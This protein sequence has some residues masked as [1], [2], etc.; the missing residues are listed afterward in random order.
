MAQNRELFDKTERECRGSGIKIEV[1]LKEI[2][3][4]LEE[5]KRI[6]FT[7]SKDWFLSH[8]DNLN[9]YYN[10]ILG[11]EPDI[12]MVR[13]QHQRLRNFFSTNIRRGLSQVEKIDK[14][15]DQNER[16]IICG[17]SLTVETSAEDHII[18]IAMGGR[19]NF[20]NIQ[21]VCE[22]CNQGKS[23]TTNFASLCAWKI[24]NLTL[25]EGPEL[26]LTLRYAALSRDGY[27]C[28]I[29]SKT[30][31]ETRLYVV[32]KVDKQFGGQIVYDNLTTACESC[33]L[34]NGKEPGDE[35]V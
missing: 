26:T 11:Y 2:L 33:L 13:T 30:S 10:N 21:L 32:R 17:V 29:C 5:R 7:P 25:R 28:T 22:N 9:E 16:C 31:L 34:Q 4:E 24:S 6:L 12:E 35:N 20:E 19:D 3:L 18:P 1:F 8:P 23:D 27:K 15:S 14:L